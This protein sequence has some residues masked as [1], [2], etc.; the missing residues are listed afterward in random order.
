VNLFGGKFETGAAR[1]AAA[2]ALWASLAGLERGQCVR[3]SPLAAGLEAAR[4]PRERTPQAVMAI[5]SDRA[6]GRI[7]ASIERE[8]SQ[9]S[10]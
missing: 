3:I 2:F 7:S 6:A 10:I 4:R 1:A 8:A 5:E 9:Y